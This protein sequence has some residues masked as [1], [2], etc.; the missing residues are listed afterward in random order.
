[1]ASSQI[2]WS[3]P[4][5]KEKRGMADHHFL[6]TGQEKRKKK[7]CD[8]GNGLGNKENRKKAPSSV[9]GTTVGT[10][11]RQE[12]QRPGTG[13]GITTETL[14]RRCPQFLETRTGDQSW[15]S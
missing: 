2:P 4:G 7:E 13:L 14:T 9:L 15:Y 11:S 5:S 6:G 8:P 12:K 10:V 1:M 3:R